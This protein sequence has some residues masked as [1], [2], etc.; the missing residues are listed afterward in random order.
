MLDGALATTK[1][2]ALDILCVKLIIFY[3]AHEDL[4]KLIRQFNIS[5]L[6]VAEEA[7]DYISVCIKNIQG[8][9]RG[10]IKHQEY[11]NSILNLLYLLSISPLEKVE[12]ESIYAIVLNICKSDLSWENDKLIK[13]LDKLIDAYRPNPELASKLLMTLAMSKNGGSY[14]EFKSSYSKLTKIISSAH[15]HLPEFQI[16]EIL[17][18]DK[19]ECIFII[20]PVVPDS[21]KSEFVE[22]ISAKIKRLVSYLM[23]VSMYGIEVNNDVN[24]K[25]LIQ[26]QNPNCEEFCSRELA[27]LRNDVKYK[28]LHELI[29]ANIENHKL[30]SFYLSPLD[31]EDI[32]KI[33]VS[34]I[35]LCSHE[36]KTA[37]FKTPICREKLIEFLSRD[38]ISEADRKSCI[39][40][41]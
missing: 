38:K 6:S 39:K 31:Y 34:E 37:L 10:L 33:S 29:D 13:F 36:Q 4:I 24:L 2:T 26:Q 9:F 28:C 35:M 20:Y 41:L 18:G 14:Q 22:K 27:N 40:Y 32:E 8:N 12:I 15:S 21:L 25:R 1:L 3:I 17:V 23:F 19:T 7:S 30:I 11:K 16:D 5:S